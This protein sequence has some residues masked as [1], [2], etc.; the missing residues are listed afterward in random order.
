MT[1]VCVCVT[2]QQGQIQVLSQRLGHQ[3]REGHERGVASAGLTN[4]TAAQERHCLHGTLQEV[5]GG[6]GGGSGGVEGGT[7][8]GRMFYLNYNDRKHLDTSTRLNP[9]PPRPSLWTNHFQSRRS[10]TTPIDHWQTCAKCSQS[11]APTCQSFAPNECECFCCDSVVTDSTWVCGWEVVVLKSESYYCQI[12]NR[13]S[14]RLQ[15]SS[16]Y[17]VIIRPLWK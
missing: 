15:G 3:S 6:E 16:I 9:S 13:S 7:R 11:E 4:Q 5:G 12:I 14:I 10:A 1:F 17:M 8:G 2:L